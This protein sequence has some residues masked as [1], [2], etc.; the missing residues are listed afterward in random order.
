MK[1]ILSVLFILCLCTSIEC[2]NN[3]T[4]TLKNNKETITIN[5]EDDNIKTVV[6]STDYPTDESVYN[7]DNIN[8]VA[9]EYKKN[10]END[11]GEGSVLNTTASVKNGIIT[12]VTEIDFERV[13]DLTKFGIGST[14]PSYK[15]FVSYLTENGFK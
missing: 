15:E 6:F 2:T 13:Q 12:L 8:Q 10:L 3:K 4:T 9:E 7:N 5:H 14:Y 11:Y 1:K